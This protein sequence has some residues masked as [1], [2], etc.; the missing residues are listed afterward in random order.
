MIISI[1]GTSGSG[2]STL[3]RSLMSDPKPIFELNQLVGHQCSGFR[4]VGPY[5]EDARLVAGV[6]LLNRTR[7]S[8]L[9]DQIQRWA[10]LGDVIYEGLLVSNE[11]GRTVRLA[12][13][14]ST[15]VIFLNTPL[16]VCLDRINGRRKSKASGSLFGEEPDAVNPK[17]TTEKFR[18]LERVADRLDKAG[19]IVCRQ[20]YDDALGHCRELLK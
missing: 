17:N 3:V 1:R 20:S 5:P 11:V 4:V 6:D 9:Y 18:K 8:E 12:Q 15:V 13:I 16:D 7:R 19:V 10:I 2:K 14:F